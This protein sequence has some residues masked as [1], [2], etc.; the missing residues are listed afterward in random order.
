MKWNVVY[1]QT[2]RMAALRSFK[3]SAAAAPHNI[4]LTGQHFAIMHRLKVKQPRPLLMLLNEHS[5][6]RLL[7]PTTVVV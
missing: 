5:K 7:L 3:G 2:K 1:D 4:N 6:I